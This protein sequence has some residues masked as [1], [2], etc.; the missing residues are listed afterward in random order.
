VCH[1]KQSGAVTSHTQHLP[2]LSLLPP[3]ARARPPQHPSTVRPPHTPHNDTLP[4]LPVP[5][6]AVA[7]LALAST[8]TTQLVMGRLCAHSMRMHARATSAH[9]YGC[10]HACTPP[11]PLALLP[12]C[13]T[14]THPRA[15]TPLGWTRKHTRTLP[16]PQ[17]SLR[18]G[19]PSHSTRN[20]VQ[21]MGGPA[22]R[23]PAEP[24]HPTVCHSHLSPHNTHL[25]THGRPPAPQA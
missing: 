5:L 17:Q 11:S 22:Q 19:L 14:Q 6:G 16:P 21:Q 4:C 12:W 13:P 25:H 15:C 20:S 9:S 18:A 10:M 3:H 1:S 23:T 24:P 8:P 7:M 2:A